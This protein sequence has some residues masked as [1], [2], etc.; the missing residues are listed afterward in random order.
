VTKEKLDRR[1]DIPLHASFSLLAED[2]VVTS[3]KPRESKPKQASLKRATIKKLMKDAVII[4]TIAEN[5]GLKISTIERYI[6]EILRDED[7]D[8]DLD[9]FGITEDIEMNILEAIKKVGTE[10]LRPI[11]D[12]IE[13]HI[14]W[15]QIKVYL[16]V[17]E[18]E[19][20]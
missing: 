20:M 19:T 11:K 10:K 6:I 7:M 17:F 2:C 12:L 1:P 4:E 13:E 9:Y 18:I 3:K 15:L 5:V 14:T 8:I 16:L